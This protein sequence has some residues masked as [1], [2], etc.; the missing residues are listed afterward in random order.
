MKDGGNFFS[1]NVR[2]SRDEIKS[3]MDYIAYIAEMHNLQFLDAWD[4]AMKHN[5]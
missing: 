5:E 1:A 4:Y 3:I 2:I